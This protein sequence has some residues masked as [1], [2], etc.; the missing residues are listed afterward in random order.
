MRPAEQ[1]S[2][3]RGVACVEG[4]HGGA[5]DFS[6]GLPGAAFLENTHTGWQEG[7]PTPLLCSVS[8]ASVNDNGCLTDLSA[9]FTFLLS[10]GWS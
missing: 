1:S 8:L 6:Q 9:S 2:L 4:K 5:A 7:G 3:L 10:E